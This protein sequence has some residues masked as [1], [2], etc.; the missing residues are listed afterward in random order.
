MQYPDTE[1]VIWVNPD[2]RKV[3]VPSNLLNIA[4]AGDIDSETVHIRIPKTFDNIDFLDRDDNEDSNIN[5]RENTLDVTKENGKVYP[6]NTENKKSVSNIKNCYIK[7]L[8]SR[9]EYSEYKPIVTE[10]ECKTPFEQDEDKESVPCLD[11]AWALESPAT[12]VPGLLNF[13]ILFKRVKVETDETTQKV[14]STKTYQWQSLPGIINIMQS[15]DMPQKDQIYKT[16][17]D[18]FYWEVFSQ[19]AELRGL[20]GN[21]DVT[22]LVDMK[23]K[24]DLMQQTIDELKNKIKIMKMTRATDAENAGAIELQSFNYADYDDTDAIKEKVTLTSESDL[25]E[26]YNAIVDVNG[27][28]VVE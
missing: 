21:V 11:I 22:A 8:N 12:D 24:V 13:S 14:T 25:M 4:V 9:N 20:L 28:E 15:I 1:G 26:I 23:T 2:T 27:E 10:V 17:T 19:I 16:Q 6:D 3:I 18:Q 7:I 5:S